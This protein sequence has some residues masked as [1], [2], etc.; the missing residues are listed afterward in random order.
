MKKYLFHVGIDIS[1]SKLDVVL[2]NGTMTNLTDHFI[3]ENTHKGVKSILNLLRRKKI[4]PA[5]VLFCCENTGVYTFPVSIVLSESK[6]DYWIV[7]AIEIK[8]SKGISRGKNDKTDAKDIALYSLRNI[9][10]LKLSNIAEKEILE[11][12]LLYTEREKVL[13]A[14]RLFQS[15]EENKDFMPKGIY[16]SIASVNKKTLK[17]LKDARKYLENKIIAV[18]KVNTILSQQLEL[19]QSVPGIGPQTAQYMIIATKGFTAFNSWRQFACYSGVAPFEY[20]SGSSVRGRTKVNHMADKK[21]KSL[22]QMCA[23][24]A[25]KYDAQLKEYYEKKKD[26]G[27]HTMLVLNNIRCKI[28]SRAF[29]VISRQQPYINTY[30]FAN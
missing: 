2:M 13:K 18:I 8:R 17:S 9:D 11:L 3:V 22:L 30:K 20:S 29:S 19:L 25:V 4:D 10:K 14:I 24:S 16:K 26:E 1:K 21:I 23:L 27:K 5:T 6:L 7:P 15:S 12:R 28:I